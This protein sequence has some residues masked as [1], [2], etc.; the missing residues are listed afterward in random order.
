MVSANGDMDDELV[1]FELAEIKAQLEIAK[2]SNDVKWRSFIDVRS[3]RRRIFV[4]LL[5][6]L[7]TQLSG[8]GVVQYYLVPI[9]R[10]VGITAPPQTAGINGGLAVFN[11]F[12][13]MTGATLVERFGRRPLFLFSLAGQL[14]CFIMLT[15]LAGGYD[16]TKIAAMGVSM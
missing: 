2:Q 16:A 6:G 4:V 11:W 5:I 14:F 9:L 12:V 7:C 1:M 15:G 8:N 10:T 3:N 13:A